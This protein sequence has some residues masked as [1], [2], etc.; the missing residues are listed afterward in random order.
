M[1][2]PNGVMFHQPAVVLVS[3]GMLAGP[4]PLNFLVNDVPVPVPA[5]QSPLNTSQSVAV[6]SSIDG[7]Y[8]QGV[9]REP[10]D[11]INIRPPI[12][13]M[14]TKGL[15]HAARV[16]RCPAQACSIASVKVMRQDTPTASNCGSR[17]QARSH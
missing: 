16:I 8:V 2:R 5:Y 7:E 6:A 13:M 14:Y 4:F 17:R 9:I 3:V 1:I 10:T 15:P 11:T 12:P